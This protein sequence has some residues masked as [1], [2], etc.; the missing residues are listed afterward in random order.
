MTRVGSPIATFAPQSE[1]VAPQ[2][3]KK[4]LAPSGAAVDAAGKLGEVKGGVRSGSMV[5]PDG[6]ELKFTTGGNNRPAIGIGP[7]FYRVHTFEP[8]SVGSIREAGPHSFK[9]R[10]ESELADKK[11]FHDTVRDARLPWRDRELLRM[12]PRGHGSAGANG[13]IAFED[14]AKAK[15]AMEKFAGKGKSFVLHLE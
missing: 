1:R 14:P 4:L 7:G 9:V 13:Y 6:S 2:E 12:G 8:R 11:P 15:A 5:L 3:P 10:I